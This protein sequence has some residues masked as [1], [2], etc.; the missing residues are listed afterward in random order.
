MQAF[1]F[2]TFMDLSHLKN[3]KLEKKV[4]KVILRRTILGTTPYS[5]S[6]M[7][8]A[9]HMTAAKVPDNI[10]RFPHCSGPASDAM[11]AHKSK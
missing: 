1:H 2:A 7:A 11:S 8:P 6:Y 10:S 3:S 5:R 9:S 4:C